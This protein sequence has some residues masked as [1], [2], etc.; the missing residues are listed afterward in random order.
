MPPNTLRDNFFPESLS[1]VGVVEQADDAYRVTLA[2]RYAGTAT[3]G[4]DPGADIAALTAILRRV[5]SAPR[6]EAESERASTD[7]AANQFMPRE[8]G[9]STDRLPRQCSGLP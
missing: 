4:R 9:R 1:D 6:R 8:S 7:G 3:D 2:A 5:E